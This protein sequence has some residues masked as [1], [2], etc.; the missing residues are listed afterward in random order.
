MKKEIVKV[1]QIDVVKRNIG[2]EDVNSVDARDLHN[3]L[4]SKQQFADWV[5]AKVIN[6]PFFEENQDYIM[7]QTNL[8]LAMT[9][10]SAGGHNKKDYALTLDTAKKV[11]M[12]EQTAKGNEV[13]EYFI[14]CE[15]KAKNSIFRLPDFT[16]PV[17][18]AEAFIRE[19]KAKIMLA[20][21]LHKQKD[22][23]EFYDTVVDSKGASSMSKVAKALD[24]GIG[25][26]KLF[27]FLREES[28]LQEDNEPYQRYITSGYFR[29]VM[30]KYMSGNMSVTHYTTLVTNKGVDFILRRYLAVYP[31]AT[32][33]KIQDIIQ[34]ATNMK[35]SDIIKSDETD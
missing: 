3:F 20:E 12:A 34:T 16:N 11:A 1:N 19:Y 18:A 7:L 21:E 28:I 17:E 2:N 22:K 15:K 24:L 35:I 25:R 26:N 27:A 32:K 8:K 5:K 29:I 23:I 33:N 4:E 6:N 14:E 30:N 31:E 9:G 13:R 10:V